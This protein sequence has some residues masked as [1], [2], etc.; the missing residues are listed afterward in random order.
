[1]KIKHLRESR[2]MAYHYGL[3]QSRTLLNFRIKFQSVFFFEG[4]IQNKCVILYSYGDDGL[5]LVEVMKSQINRY[6]YSSLEESKMRFTTD[7]PNQPDLWAC[8]ATEHPF[9]VKDKGR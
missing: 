8:C 4:D 2:R 7:Q 5:R 6:T 3:N 1:M 9:F